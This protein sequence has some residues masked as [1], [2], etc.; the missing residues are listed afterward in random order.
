MRSRKYVRLV[1]VL[2]VLLP[3]G[4]AGAGLGQ[5]PAQVIDSSRVI[6]R[7]GPA[8]S[9]NT[10]RA[11][12]AHAG[13]RL[14]A[15]LPQLRSAIGA[16]PAARRTTTLSLLRRTDGVIDAEADGSVRAL[17]Q[18]ASPGNADVA[19]A[20]WPIAR[21]G[22]PLAWQVTRGDPSIVIAVVDSGVQAD[23][24]GLGSRVLP[25]RNLIDQ[26]DDASDDNGHGTAVAGIIAS[27]EGAGG[28]AGACLQCRILPVKVLAA[29]G[30]GDWSTVAAGIVW[31]ADHGAQVINVSFGA[32]R[33]LDVV[34][35][36]VSYAIAEGAIVVAAAGNDGKN[37]SFYPAAYPG[38]VSVAGVDAGDRRYSWSNFGSWVSVAAPGCI[39]TTWLRGQ[40]DSSFCGTSASAPFVAGL[41]GLARAFRPELA[42]AAF[43][44]ALGA[45]ALPLPDPGTAASGRVDANRLLVALGAP[46]SPPSLT[47]APSLTNAPAVGRPV[48]ADHG[49]W[50][51]ARSFAYR[52]QR[53]RDGRSW[54]DLG[55][56]AIYKPRAIDRG[57]RLR[58]VVSAANV[59]GSVSATSAASTRVMPAARPASRA[60][61]ST[62]PHARRDRG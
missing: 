17:Y 13:V 50:Q 24:P 23:H 25:G 36:A 60:E 20:S 21:T 19:S 48:A 30:T 4:S 56:G 7:F 29:D 9:R 52:W 32:P 42:S 10:E 35:A 59:R 15:T 18:G 16:V 44:A 8:I 5:R 6:V 2:A 57:C 61:A 39:S 3:G 34:G 46:T 1:S 55:S 51:G 45:S 47:S 38:V 11:L 62:T 22:L 43:A 37:E 31:A 53:S 40:Y 49:G 27:A 12:L 33:A 41:A 58:V 28:S 26:S 54:Q 14:V